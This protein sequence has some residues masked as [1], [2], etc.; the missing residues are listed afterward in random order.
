LAQDGA[1]H[2]VLPSVRLGDHIDAQADATGQHDALEDDLERQVDD[3]DGFRFL[4]GFTMRSNAD[5]DEI[6]E[7]VQGAI[8][9]ILP[10][11][12][13][14]GKL[15]GWI[16]WNRDGDWEDEGEQV[17]I[18]EDI[19]SE[20]KEEEA[21]SV[22][23]PEDADLGYS[24]ARFRFSRNGNLS[25]TGVAPGGEVEDY[26]LRIVDGA[27]STPVKVAEGMPEDFALYPAY[28]NPFNPQ[29]LIRYELSHSTQVRLTIFDAIG[30]KVTVLV[31]EQQV[32][33]RYE[34]IFDAEDLPSGV[35]M[36]R[37]E[38]GSF[39]QARTMLLVK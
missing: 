1:R 35:Y 20:M 38:A 3:E 12:S 21:L 31:D 13:T 18:S 14:D 5:A 24:Y 4:D 8:V 10:L 6:L 33:G 36:Y 15:D 19:H 22:D 30:R 28:P 26:L 39:T 37:L 25:F 11:P 34:A 27:G 2:A 23:V 7:I 16:D 32:A 17:F 29:T 9:K